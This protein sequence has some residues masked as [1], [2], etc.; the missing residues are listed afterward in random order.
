MYVTIRNRKDGVTEL[1]PK[2]APADP[3][4]RFVVIGTV[5]LGGGGL[6]ICGAMPALAFGIIAAGSLAGEVVIGIRALALMVLRP[7]AH[8]VPLPSRVRR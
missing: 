3:L 5:L 6:F 7:P 1:A 2:H 8:V 4:D